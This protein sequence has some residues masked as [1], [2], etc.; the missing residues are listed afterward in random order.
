[1]WMI[2]AILRDK[3]ITIYNNSFLCK[4]M[5][6]LP[7]ALLLHRSVYYLVEYRITLI[8]WVSVLNRMS[9]LVLFWDV[10]TIVKGSYK[11]M[12]I[13]ALRF[14]LKIYLRYIS[15]RRKQV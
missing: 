11:C 13:N 12:E 4:R 3:Y 1:M 10:P 15:F 14:G 2:G 7:D 6:L 9:K 8:L 5:L